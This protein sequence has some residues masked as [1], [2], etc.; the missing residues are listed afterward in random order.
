MMRIVAVVSAMA[1]AV[2][3]IAA[4]QDARDGGAQDQGQRAES[5]ADESGQSAYWDR[6]FPLPGESYGMFPQ[7]YGNPHGDIAAA[8]ADEG[9]VSI[10]G[11][12]DT[13]DPAEQTAEISPAHEGPDL[14]DASGGTRTD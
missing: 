2:P 7:V 10:A 14:R 8:L 6:I 4:E 1:L 13:R 5:T 12:P 9:D 3:A 11:D